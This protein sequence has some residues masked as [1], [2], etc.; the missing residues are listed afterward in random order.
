VAL[1][2]GLQ[3]ARLTGRE[4][5]HK[6]RPPAGQSGED[7]PDAGLNASAESEEAL[8]QD[9]LSG[10]ESDPPIEDSD[11]AWEQELRTLIDAWPRR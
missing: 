2:W 10:N 7:H 3:C 4:M 1:L 6:S 8:G 9:A 11:R 5:L